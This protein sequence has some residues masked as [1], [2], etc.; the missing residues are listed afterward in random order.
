M[1]NFLIISRLP[2]TLMPYL[3]RY[4]LS[5]CFNLTQGKLS[6]PKQYFSIHYLLTVLG[7]AY[8]ASFRFEAVI[9]SAT[10]EWPSQTRSWITGKAS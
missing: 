3:V 8:D 1:Q 5:K 7:F 2:I 9:T 6:Q 4:R 10:G